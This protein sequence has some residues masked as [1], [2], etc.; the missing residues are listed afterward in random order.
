MD[1]KIIALINERDYK[2]LELLIEHLGNDIIRTISA[3]L[4]RSEEHSYHEETENEVFYRL[5]K[6]I[7]IFDEEKSSLKTWVLT[8]TRN[9]CIDKKRAILRI[10]DTSPLEQSEAFH[11]YDRPLEKELFLELVS[12]LDTEDQIIF[13]DHYFYQKRP[14]EIA[15]QLNIEV[16]QVY[17]RLSR[18]RKKLKKQ[19]EEETDDGKY[20]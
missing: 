19:L 20:I 10:A 5:W 7:P 2:G 13:L 3:V 11:S 16:S 12:S 9:I 6:N 15:A 1:R 18:G 8:I 17:N 4:N 14:Q